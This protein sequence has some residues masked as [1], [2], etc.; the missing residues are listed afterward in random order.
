MASL[1][2]ILDPSHLK[3][4]TALGY[5]SDDSGEGPPTWLAGWVCTGYGN[6]NSNTAGMANCNAWSTTSGY[7]T[8]V[9]LSHTWTAGWENIHV[10]IAGTSSC[11]LTSQVW[12]VEDHIIYLPLIL[13]NYGL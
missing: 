8:N 4:N 6:Y 2:E 1:W 11:S 5:T 9:A 13:R 3:Y 10:W 7:G 12:C